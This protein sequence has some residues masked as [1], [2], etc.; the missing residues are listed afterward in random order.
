M[1]LSEADQDRI[2]AAIKAAERK[3]SGE[4]VC[5]LARSSSDYMLYPVAWAVVLALV[6][7]WLLLAFTQFPVQRILLIQLALFIVSFLLLSAPS[8][9]AILVPRGVRRTEAHRAAMEQFMIRGLHRTEN[10]AA[11]LIFVSLAEHYA[12]IVADDGIASK[13]DQKIWQG[14]VDAVLAGARSDRLADGF[15][16]AIE[17]CGAVQAVHFPP[18]V[19]QDV[20]PN[21]IFVI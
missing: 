3:T 21:R 5:V 16:E 1:E 17:Q 10:R 19:Q 11:V 6:S 12:R 7:P 15:V 18:H 14:A 8:L 20:L 9:R 2:S 4:I 13:V